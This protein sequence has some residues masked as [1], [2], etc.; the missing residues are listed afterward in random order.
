MD[1]IVAKEKRRNKE[2][3]FIFMSDMY[4]RIIQYRKQIQYKQFKRTS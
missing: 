2:E 3:R 1:K 4:Q